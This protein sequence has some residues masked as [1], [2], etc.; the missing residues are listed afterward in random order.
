MAKEINFA[1]FPSKT[2]DA[3][4]P[5]MAAQNRSQ[6]ADYDVI[7]IDSSGRVYANWRDDAPDACNDK[8]INGYIDRDDLRNYTF[9]QE[10]PS[11]RDGIW[12]FTVA[13]SP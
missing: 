3:N 1:K 8:T 9:A 7:F 12:E 6:F 4:L 11:S 10:C 2:G 13:T 5:R